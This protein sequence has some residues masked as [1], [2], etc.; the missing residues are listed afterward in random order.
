M[1]NYLGRALSCIAMAGSLAVAQ[2]AYAQYA[3]ISDPYIFFDHVMSLRDPPEALNEGNSKQGALIIKRGM[4]R[5][6]FYKF[7]D[8]IGNKD[9][10]V[11]EQEMRHALEELSRVYGRI[12]DK[13]AGNKDG[14]VIQ[15]ELRRM[16]ATMDRYPGIEIINFM[17]EFGIKPHE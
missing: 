10:T 3:D 8:K 2:P 11:T 1:K 13:Y 6:L 15:E 5:Q 9:G 16:D 14:K 17:K 7:A 4:A 12:A